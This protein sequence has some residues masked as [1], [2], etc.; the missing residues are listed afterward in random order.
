MFNRSNSEV[1]D[2]NGERR[3]Q[4]TDYLANAN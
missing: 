1:T 3:N 4:V 2:T